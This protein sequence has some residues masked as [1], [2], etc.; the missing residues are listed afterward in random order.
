MASIQ[1]RFKSL[2][3][4]SLELYLRKM[5]RE[6]SQDHRGVEN[7]IRNIVRT[8][9]EATIQRVYACFNRMIKISST[10]KCGHLE[11]GHF[12]FPSFLHITK[13][14]QF[15][16]CNNIVVISILFLSLPMGHPVNKLHLH[17]MFRQKKMSFG[18]M[19]DFMLW[20]LWL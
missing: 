11:S 1:S 3:L 12:T 19:T 6:A 16:T 18:A 17:N 7:A 15:F 20:F 13:K 2:W 9:N 8:I 14:Q 4:Q 5:L 10:S